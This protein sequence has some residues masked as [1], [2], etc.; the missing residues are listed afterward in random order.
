M[1][2]AYMS[3]GEVNAHNGTYTFCTLNRKHR[4]SIVATD[5]SV[6]YIQNSP[7]RGSVLWWTIEN[8]AVRRN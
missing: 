7:H 6:Q 4:N 1:L 3:L 5:E 8:I 2:N